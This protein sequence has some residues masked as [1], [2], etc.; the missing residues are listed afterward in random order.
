MEGS[1]ATEGTASSS[2]P[3]NDHVQ[4]GSAQ[5]LRFIEHLKSNPT[6][7]DTKERHTAKSHVDFREEKWHEMAEEFNM[8]CK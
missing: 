6:L 3:A 8:P 1:A 2:P 4:H 7:Y 5:E